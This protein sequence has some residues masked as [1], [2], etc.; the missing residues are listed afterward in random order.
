MGWAERLEQCEGFQWDDANADKIW[1]CH[2]VTPNECE[3]A[4]FNQPLVLGEDEKH[5]ETEERL[6]ALGHTDAGRELFVAF[7]L[8][9]RLIRVISARDMSRKERKIYRAS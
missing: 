5:S 2:G 3:E 9:G 7:T 6:Y 8:R 4:F 1:Q